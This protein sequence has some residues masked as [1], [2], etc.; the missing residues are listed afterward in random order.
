MYGGLVLGGSEVRRQVVVLED[1]LL[2]GLVAGLDNRGHTRVVLLAEMVVREP[3]V[4]AARVEG[5]LELMPVVVVVLLVVRE[6]RDL[7]DVHE[8]T[9]SLVREARDHSVAFGPDAVLVVL[10]LGFHESERHAVH[11]EDDVGP[12]AIL[13]VR[14]GQLGEH[15]EAVVCQV[16]EVHEAVAFYAV[17]EQLEEGLA[18]VVRAEGELQLVDDVR[19][20]RHV[21]LTT[22]YAFER[23]PELLVEDV[24]VGVVVRIWLETVKRKVLVADARCVDDRGYLDVLV[25]WS[26]HADHRLSSSERLWMA[27]RRM[28][29]EK[30]IP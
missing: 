24:R 30:L 9:E 8:A 15:V 29:A 17:L 18:E 14:I 20:T 1:V 19:R 16:V 10:P 7:R 25:L 23:I 4:G 6:R 13:A 21:N 2:H 5:A 28:K 27:Q 26:S 12:E 3:S 11:E 22:V